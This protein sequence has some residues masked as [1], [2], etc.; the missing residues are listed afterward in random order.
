MRSFAEIDKSRE[1]LREKFS[2]DEIVN[3]KV[4]YH[5]AKQTAGDYQ[6]SKLFVYKS[7]DHNSL[8]KWLTK[9]FEQ[10]HFMIANE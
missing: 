6:N 2:E 1:F 5:E 3:L 4:T 8:G 7:F 9:P 10:N